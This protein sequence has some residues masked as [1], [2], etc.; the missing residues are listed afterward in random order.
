MHFLST[1][2][3]A[4]TL[5]APSLAA[6]SGVDRVKTLSA[7]DVRTGPSTPE[8]QGTAI[9]DPPAVGKPTSFDLD[10]KIK[11]WLQTEMTREKIGYAAFTDG[12]WEGWMQYEFD[13]Y[14]KTVMGIPV[15]QRIREVQVYDGNSQAADFTFAPSE[16]RNLRGMVVELKCENKNSNT[17]KSL[18]KAVEGDMK[19]LKGKFKTQYQDYDKVAI[20]MAYSKDAQK[21][22]DEIKG[23]VSI[24]IPGSGIAVGTDKLKI[25]RWDAEDELGPVKSD[26][27]NL[28]FNDIDKCKR[29]ASACTGKTVKASSSTDKT[30]KTKKASSSTGNTDKTGKAS[31]STDKTGKTSKTS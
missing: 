8:K 26:T 19:K 11:E 2:L 24:A 4:G 23:M 29:D 9:N 5:L 20:A 28:G 21:A 25:Y 10:E 14:I 22:L 17:G 3:V 12:G 1:I 6:P 16:Q 31:S 18:G 7:L 15:K 30:D 27:S 13:F